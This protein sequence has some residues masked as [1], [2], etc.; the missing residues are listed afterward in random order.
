V[1]GAAALLHQADPTA[2][3]DRVKF[4]LME[5]ARPL[6]SAHDAGRGTIDVTAAL[7]APAG[8]ANQ[9]N[10]HPLLFPSGLPSLLDL[11][12]TEYEGTSWQGT[13]WQGTSWQGTS[14]Q[15]TSWQGTS[16]QGTSWQGTSWQGT[17]W[18]GT[19]W[20]GTSWQGTSWQ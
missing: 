16:W 4:A 15:G 19:S 3:N 10:F 17:S 7:S 18:Q 20:Q 6:A 13:S 2:T 5:T 11:L 12:G 14:W 8:E 1:A 9:S